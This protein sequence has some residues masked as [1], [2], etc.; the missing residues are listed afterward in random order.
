MKSLLRFTSIFIV[1]LIIGTFNSQAQCDPLGADDCPDPED[2]GQVCPD[3]L[4]PGFLNQPYSVVATILPPAY[5][6]TLSLQIEINH[7]TLDSV[8]NLPDGLTWVSNAPGDE[9]YPGTYYC[10]LMEG[11]PTVADTFQLRIYIGIFVEL[12]GD[13]IKL[14][15]IVDSTSLAIT[16][17]DNT[18]IAEDRDS[19]FYVSSCT[20]NPFTT[21]V[22]LS[23][24]AEEPGPVEFEVFN[25]TGMLVDTRKASAERGD[26]YFHYDGGHLPSGV[27]FYS[28]KSGGRA[29]AGKIVRGE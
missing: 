2:N 9:F 3:T 24:Y 12:L 14:A 29:A 21:W 28:L 11:T 20:P 1:A 18:G 27:Y 7:I 15:Q 4:A 8:V 6:D 22:S 26:N 16:I 5:I 23:Y 25:L 13:T 10:I 19:R 17:I